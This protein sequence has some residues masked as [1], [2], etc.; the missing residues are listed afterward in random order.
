MTLWLSMFNRVA[1]YIHLFEEWLVSILHVSDCVTTL[2]T[3]HI[4]SS[5]HLQYIDMLYGYDSVSYKMRI[6]VVLSKER[7]KPIFSATINHSTDISDYVKSLAGPFN[8]FFLQP[9][10][11]KDIIPADKHKAFKH[12]EI[13]TSDLRMHNYTDLE[14]RIHF[15]YDLDWPKYDIDERNKILSRMNY[16]D[17]KTNHMGDEQ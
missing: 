1:H 15:H 7:R 2:E 13:M 16:L 10:K 9:L 12:L 17:L 5:K 4:M 6:P 3:E 11:V 8:N 14:D